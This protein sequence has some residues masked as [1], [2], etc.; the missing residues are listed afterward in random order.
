MKYISIYVYKL[1]LPLAVAAK[2]Q[3]GGSWAFVWRQHARGRSEKR[4]HQHTSFQTRWWENI[5]E[6][7]QTV[8]IVVWELWTSSVQR[9]GLH[10]YARAYLSRNIWWVAFPSVCGPE[11]RTELVFPLI[12]I[13]RRR[14]FNICKYACK[15]HAESTAAEKWA[16]T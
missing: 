7:C 4:F 13:P 8:K 11:M 3:H 10:A 15:S 12:L 2:N 6:S 1:H 5:C 9:C 14:H 16:F